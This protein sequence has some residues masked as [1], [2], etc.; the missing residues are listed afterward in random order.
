MKKFLAI[1][2]AVMMVMSISGAASAA[3][4]PSGCCKGPWGPC[5]IPN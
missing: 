1:A 5:C 2:F 4:E 3:N